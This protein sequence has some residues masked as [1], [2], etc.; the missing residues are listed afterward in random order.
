M[1]LEVYCAFF[2]IYN[3]TYQKNFVDSTRC[4]R[5]G[6]ASSDSLVNQPCMD[7]D[8]FSEAEPT[9]LS[10]YPAIAKHNS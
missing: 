6:V 5:G 4:E 2:Y 9:P 8:L 10:S 7:V 3:V 1:Y